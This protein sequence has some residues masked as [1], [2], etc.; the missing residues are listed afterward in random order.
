M[1]KSQAWYKRDYDRLVCERPPFTP[2]TYVF[3]ENPP[4]RAKSNLAA[5]YFSIKEY[6]KLQSQTSGPFRIISVQENT[7][8]IKDNS[9]P[10]AVS[11]DRVT[12]SSRVAP[13]LPVSNRSELAPQRQRKDKQDS[14]NNEYAVE[15][16]IIHMG[17]GRDTK[18]V[19]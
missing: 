15:R 14:S 5:K 6:N 8:T 4:L 3:P 9:T 17:K 2:N 10:N 12:Q 16:I 7:V 11:I 18:Y 13:P 19:V 1:R